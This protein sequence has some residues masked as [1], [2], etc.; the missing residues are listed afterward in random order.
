MFFRGFCV[1]LFV[2]CIEK[3]FHCSVASR[4]MCPWG[5]CSWFSSCFLTADLV[6]W[7]EHSTVSRAARHLKC[8]ALMPAEVTLGSR[9]TAEM[10]T[11][12]TPRPG[13]LT[14]PCLLPSQGNSFILSPKQA[15]DGQASSTDSWPTAWLWESKPSQ[16]QG[17]LTRDGEACL[18]QA[19]P[20]A[21][22]G[23]RGQRK[24]HYAQG[25]LRVWSASAA[26]AGCPCI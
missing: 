19:A 18:E 7:I 5:T 10:S 9:R 11:G 14:F 2:F 17:K 4:S 20:V 16:S 26:S 13:A 12:Y 22:S 8:C 21:P 6:D 3:N 25:R 15:L 23:M 1:C 24:R